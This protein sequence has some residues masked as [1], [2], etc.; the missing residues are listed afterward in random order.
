VVVADVCGL[1]F[2][3]HSISQNSSQPAT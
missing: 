3:F 2:L 1:L